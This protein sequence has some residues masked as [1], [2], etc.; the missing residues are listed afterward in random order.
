M[1]AEM[2]LITGCG[3]GVSLMSL[4]TQLRF[5]EVSG[6]EIFRFHWGRGSEWQQGSASPRWL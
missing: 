5:P 6:S 1:H 2:M 4:Q 3:M